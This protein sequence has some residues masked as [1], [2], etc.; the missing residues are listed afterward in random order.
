[1]KLS[2]VVPA[3]NE[4]RLLGGTLDSIQRAV[5]I[6]SCP[7]E[8]IVCDNN[9]TDRT[10]EIARA[11]G[12]KVV[13]EPVNQIARARNA[14]AAAASGDWLVFIDADSSP[15]KE[16]LAEM[17]KAM[18]SNGIVGGGATVDLNNSRPDIKAWVGLWNAM[19]RTLSWAA[20]SFIFCRA[21]AFR[22]IGGFSTE[23]YAGEEIDLSRRMKK[24]GRFVILH[25]HPLRT[26]DRKAHL[27]RPRE[28]FM[29]F[30]RFVLSGGRALRRR[31]DTY[32]WYDGRR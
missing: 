28:H 20:G 6:L 14:G 7:Y 10:G 8:I 23:F 21:D 31:E 13:F 3:Y 29:F 5:E 25:R 2:I 19:S 30:L 1:V 32:L 18:D 4:E 11:H 12:A 22:R 15:S 9:S 26:S 24:L 17:R 27:Y 16:L